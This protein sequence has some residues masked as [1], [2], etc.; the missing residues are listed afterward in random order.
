MDIS[1]LLR[2]IKHFF[3]LIPFWRL[4]ARQS[5]K[6]GRTTRNRAGNSLRRQKKTTD[7]PPDD[8]HSPEDLRRD[9]LAMAKEWQAE[10]QKWMETLKSHTP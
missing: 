6:C 8:L 7:I 4:F 1:A 9:A 2:K 3:S 5:S 10:L